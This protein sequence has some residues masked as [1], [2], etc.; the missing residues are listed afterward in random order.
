MNKT[1]FL[2]SPM[3]VHSLDVKNNQFRHYERGE[4]LLGL[5]IPYLSSICTLMYLANC[6]R[7]DISFSVKL[8]AKYNF[9]PT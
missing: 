7:P 2:S 4:E 9:P 6:T 5:E 3:V 8:L 1:H